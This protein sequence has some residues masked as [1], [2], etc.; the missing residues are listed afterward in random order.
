M[1]KSDKDATGK[2]IVR[3]RQVYKGVPIISG[4][5]IVNM[6]ANGELLSISGEVTSDL[7]LDTKPAIKVQEANK[8]ALAQMA[9]LHGVKEAQLAASEPELWIFDE[10]LLTKSTRPVELVWRMEVTAKDA[11][12][13]IREND[14]G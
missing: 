6:N 13:P 4:E 7:E 9:K 14:S 11:T 10:S 2:D 5:M 1:F 8:T 12:Q 3:Y